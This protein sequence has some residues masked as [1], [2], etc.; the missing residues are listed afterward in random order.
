MAVF[1][2]LF[3]IVESVVNRQEKLGEREEGHDIQQR[4]L[5][6]SEAETLQ[7]CCMCLNCALCFEYSKM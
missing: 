4:S 2:G 1:F 5:A 6:V 7:L 3:L